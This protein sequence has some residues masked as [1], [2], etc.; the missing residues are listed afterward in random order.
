MKNKCRDEL[1]M[2]YQEEENTV[3]D[4]LKPWVS[5]IFSNLDGHLLLIKNLNNNSKKQNLQESITVSPL[6]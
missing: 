2:H 6:L 1:L 3:F 5:L 4:Q